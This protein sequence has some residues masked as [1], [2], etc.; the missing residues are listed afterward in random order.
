MQLDG[1]SRVIATSNTYKRL[2]RPNR[3]KNGLPP[4]PGI[5]Q[6]EMECVVCDIDGVAVA[7][8]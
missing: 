5:F 4:V 8:L 3:L 1:I 2:Y 6:S 7:L